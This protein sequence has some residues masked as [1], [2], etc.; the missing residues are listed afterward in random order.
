MFKRILCALI[1]TAVMCTSSFAYT[2]DVFKDEETSAEETTPSSDGQNGVK[3]DE[4]SESDGNSQSS[5][6]GKTTGTKVPPGSII[7]NVLSPYMRPGDYY[8]YAFRQILKLY[9]DN[10]LY[11]SNET[12]VLEKMVQNILEENPNYFKFLRSI[13]TAHTTKPILTFLTWKTPP[14]V[15][16]SP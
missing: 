2:R 6:S 14:P 5:N 9:V 12:E 8:Y 11:E 10:H 15:T 16:A 7:G 4:A 1:C 13:R 3:N